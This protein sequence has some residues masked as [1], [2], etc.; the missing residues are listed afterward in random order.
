M[1]VARYGST[2]TR[3]NLKPPVPSPWALEVVQCYPQTAQRAKVSVSELGVNDTFEQT[4]S[5]YY[6]ALYNSLLSSCGPTCDTALEM[7]QTLTW[8]TGLTDLS[9]EIPIALP[10]SYRVA[11]MHL[12]GAGHL[13]NLS[14]FTVPG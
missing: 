3:T 5:S 13:R 10:S 2:Q 6:A 12:L 7:S 11:L 4:L 8:S 1:L 9:E 14:T